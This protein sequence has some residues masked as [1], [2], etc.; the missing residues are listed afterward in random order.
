MPTILLTRYLA[1]HKL[2]LEALEKVDKDRTCFRLVGDV[3]VERTV[4]ETMPAVAKNKEN[5]E[6][7]IQTLTQQLDAQKKDLNEF[8]TKHK[9]R[10]SGEGGASI[11]L[12]G[13]TKPGVRRGA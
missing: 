6:A 5:L 7:T 11:L 10:V 9:I 12:A 8:Q 4:G 13:A 1:Q 2:V 3:L